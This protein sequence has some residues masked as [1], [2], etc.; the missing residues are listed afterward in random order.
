[1]LEKITIKK[2]LIIGFSIVVC[3]NF[4]IGGIGFYGIHRL[5]NDMQNFGEN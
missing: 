1:M 3:I 2:K 5:K 4:I